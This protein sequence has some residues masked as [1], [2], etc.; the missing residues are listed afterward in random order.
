[1]ILKEQLYTTDDLWERSQ[2][3][4]RFEL[5]EGEMIEMAPTGDTHGVLSSFAGY[6][7]LRHVIERD[8]GGDV[9]GAETGFILSDDPQTVCAPDA[10]YISQD[11]LPPMTGRFYPIAPDLAVEVVSPGEYA[12]QI[13]KKVDLYLQAGTR[14]VWVIYPDARLIDVYR[15]G[16]PTLTLKGEDKLDGGDV[17]PGF[18]VTAAAVF[19]RLR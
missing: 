16:A 7:I 4:E 14:L 18:A 8:L 13:R 3:G 15:P 12:P 17:L 2:A 6:M 9:T 11:R 10:A 19:S 5:I 1:M